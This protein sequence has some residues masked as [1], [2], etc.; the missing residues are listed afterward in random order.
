MAPRVM[1]VTNTE[2]EWVN[3]GER[4][5]YESDWVNLVLADVM[6][7]DGTQV[8][9]HVVRMPNQAAGCVI[10]HDDHVLL[11]YRHRF[12]TDTWGWEIPAGK[13]DPGETPAGAARRESIE[14]S[15]WDPGELTPLCAFYPGN[16]LTDQ[17]F[18]IFT[19]NSPTHIGAP[20][21]T[22][23]A[24]RIVWHDTDSLRALLVNGRISDGLSFAA[25]S[26]ALATGA[27]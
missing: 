23:E 15:G 14:E 7:P 2:G 10:V 3:R 8:D 18:H 19:S 5:I 12:I 21:D 13:I 26:F 22:N 24:T 17:Q 9:H 4:P 20:A 6:M 11:L 25:V 16:G 27:I 1:E